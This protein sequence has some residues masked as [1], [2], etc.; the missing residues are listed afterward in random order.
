MSAGNSPEARARHAAANAGPQKGQASRKVSPWS[1]GP[2]CATRRADQRFAN[3]NRR[4]QP[5][6]SDHE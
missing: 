1:K 5:E 6:A 2:M 3:H 4:T